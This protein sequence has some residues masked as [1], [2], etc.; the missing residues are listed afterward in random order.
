MD[1][2][3]QKTTS[4]AKSTKASQPFFSKDREGSFF[5]ES[6]NK[7]SSFFKPSSQ[8]ESSLNTSKG[9]GSPLPANTK[10]QMENS[11]G[12]DFSNVRLHTDNNAVQM[13]KDLHA[14]AFTRGS[15]IYFNSGKYNPA[16][17]TGKHLLAHELTHVAQQGKTGKTAISRLED[18]T[19]IQ[20]E[21]QQEEREPKD[22]TQQ[23]P[24]P[25]PANKPLRADRCMANPEFPDFG[26]FATQLKLN[27][28][29]N[30]IN[31]AHQFLRIASLYPGDSELMWNTFMRYGMGVNLLQTSFRFLGTDKKWANILSYGSGI[32]MKAYQFTQT[33][34]LKLDFQIPLK[35]DLNLNIK[36]DLNADPND[37]T[38]IKGVDTG[39]GIS[40]RF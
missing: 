28:D 17:S 33:G 23:P 38:K 11:F 14:Q 20:R 5:G 40:G 16:T 24:S 4:V 7:E 31:N 36:F 2:S 18:Q 27:L 29:E 21:P 10:A 3:K 25:G 8:I 22:I 13:N 34:E 30:L 15:D 9:N 26:C 19:M 39:I 37:P 1:A 6:V 12:T 35:K 32:G